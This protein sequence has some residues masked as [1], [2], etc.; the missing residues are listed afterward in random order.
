MPGFFNELTRLL[1]ET[2]EQKPPGDFTTPDMREYKTHLALHKAAM[3]ILQK[4]QT[5]HSILTAN[6]S[7]LIFMKKN[8]K[9][10]LIK[11]AKKSAVFLQSLKDFGRMIAHLNDV[12]KYLN[13][14][15][16]SEAAA[17]CGFVIFSEELPA[18]TILLDEYAP[19]SEKVLEA[20]KPPE[21]TQAETPVR[22]MHAGYSF[23]RKKPR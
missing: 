11:E 9:E 6:C 21:I 14:E 4:L 5:S 13:A 2:E 12:K 16:P 18:I 23:P 8:S 20:W 15:A 17:S 10:N 7:D 19:L 22:H 3:D 1:K